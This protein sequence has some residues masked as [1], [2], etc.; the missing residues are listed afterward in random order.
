LCLL[1]LRYVVSGH[2]HGL[3]SLKLQIVTSHFDVENRAVLPV[4]FPEPRLLQS[5]MPQRYVLHQLRNRPGWPDIGDRHPQ[6]FS[7]AV[8]VLPDCSS[9]HRKKT[10]RLTMENPHRDRIALKKQPVLRIGPLKRFAREFPAT[11]RRPESRPVDA[12]GP[13]NA[14]FRHPDFHPV[15]S[16]SRGFRALACTP[17]T[18]ART[19]F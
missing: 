11:T 18:G 4:M 1:P 5:P 19:A 17:L 2:Q 14:V 3:G 10:Q 12:G 6:K 7:F 15:H 9:I 8:P 13:R 16:A